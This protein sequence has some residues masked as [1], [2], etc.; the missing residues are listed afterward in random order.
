MKHERQGRGER[1][2]LTPRWLV[3]ALGPFDL[4]PC[5][6]SPRPW[7]T[8]AEHFGPDAAGGLGGLCAAWHG[9]VWLNPPYGDRAGDWLAKLAAH[10]PGGIALVFARTETDWFVA[11]VWRKAAAV[12]F[13]FGRLVFHRADGMPGATNGGAPSCLVAYGDEAVR[14]LERAPLRG[15]IVRLARQEDLAI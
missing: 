9:F 3:E 2:W 14:R 10:P 12:M 1:V 15:Q 13:L 8:A 7:D 5:F 11:E 6:S 4:D